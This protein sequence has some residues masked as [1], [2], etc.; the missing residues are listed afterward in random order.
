[1]PT[2]SQAGNSSK[3]KLKMVDDSRKLTPEK[4]SIHS[5]STSWLRSTTSP[6]AAS[7]S[8]ALTQALAWRAAALPGAGSTSGKSG[9]E[10][11]T[12]APCCQTRSLYP[13]VVIELAEHLAPHRFQRGR[14]LL[15]ARAVDGDLAQVQQ[16]FARVGGVFAGGAG[17][18]GDLGLHRHIGEAGQ[19]HQRDH[20]GKA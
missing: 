13:R 16:H 9:S 2:I 4:L 17:A 1:M 7:R 18:L 15:H 5:S 11:Y 19:R 10:L 6:L 8:T 12:S 20:A 3:G 14:S